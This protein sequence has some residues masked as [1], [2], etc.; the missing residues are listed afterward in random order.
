MKKIGVLFLVLSI[1]TSVFAGTS[2]N[3][4]DINLND[5]VLFTV[6]H[7]TV[8][9]SS[10]NSLFYAQLKNGSPV[11]NPKIITCYP[12]RMELLSGG[13]VLQ[14]RNRYG[15]ARYSSIDDK[16][17]WIETFGGIPVDS[18]PS[19]PYAV[20]PDGKYYCRIEKT[21]LCAG[22]LVLENV[23]TGKN[24]VLCE[25]VLCSYEDLPVK[26][27]PDS[28]VLL[29]EKD[30]SVY[31]C[32]PDAVL[33]GVE[34]EERYR[35]VGRGTINS[36]FWANAKNLAYIDD[37]LLYKINT[38]ELYT[39]GLY[40][41]IIGQGKPMGRL[42]FQFNS[43]TDRFSSNEDVTSVVITQNRRLFTYLHTENPSCNYMDV[44]YSKPYSDSKASLIDSY[45]F[46]DA[47]GNPILWQEKLPYDGKAETGSVFKLASNAQ[48]VLEIQDSG[49]PFISPNGRRIAFFAGSVVYIYDVN[50]WTR[51]SELS[52][53]KIVSAIW[54]NNDELYVGGEKSIRR[55]N[56]ADNMAQTVT[57]SSAIAGYWD[58]N[59]YSIVAET[60][61]PV[62]YK[63][64]E[65]KNTW[66][67]LSTLVNVAPKKQNGRYRVFTGTTKNK[68]FENALYIRSLSKNAVT[69][70]MY[71]ESSIKTETL[72]KVALVFDLY[73][74]ADGLTKILATLK[75]YN[76]KG[77]FFVN[78]EFIRRYPSETQQI[79]ANGYN[80]SSMF[81]T[82]TNLTENSFVINEDFVRRGLAR[83]EDEFYSCTDKELS[84]YWHAPYYSVTP[85]IIE[86]GKNA[87][88]NYVSSCYDASEYDNS[89]AK[90]DK[91]IQQYYKITE[92]TNGGVIPVVGGYS[93]TYHVKPLYDYLDLLICILIDGGYEFVDITEL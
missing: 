9:S 59:D 30:G 64:S 53:E 34:I 25:D 35:K 52:G 6:K 10:Y 77:T 44:I 21:S 88:Y 90:P 68:K 33:R 81:F 71:E 54:I 18:L 39:L 85:Q 4:L 38:K 42:P 73:D 62:Y 11:E 23:E 65:S 3:N 19:T 87:G 49:K 16:L 15:K 86:W 29:Y 79:V 63:Y 5:E 43:T 67:R 76:A 66:K 70:P 75:K 24:G 28:S 17:T 55:W 13:T 45:V 40:S 51:V 93:Q 80:C 83:N 82:T 74:N 50:N 89:S 61:G 56:L 27:A 58:N 32:N 72:K 2:F 26:W 78:G 48:Q 69:K 20:S 8:G 1:C 12:E 60:N 92:K 36:V 91:L 31:F 37:Y 57:L 7:D 41:G 47:L 14:I 22:V 84:L 46:W